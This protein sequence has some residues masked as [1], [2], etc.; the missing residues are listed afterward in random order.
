MSSDKIIDSDAIAESQSVS[1]GD[2][3]ARIRAE[4]THE[5]TWPPSLTTATMPLREL[6]AVMDFGRLADAAAMVNSGK[7]LGF[8]IIS[9]EYL[10]VGFNWINAIHRI[11]LTNFIMIA[12]DEVTA[13]ALD[14]RGIPN[15]LASIDESE[16]D[17]SYVSATGF[18]AKGLAVSAFKLPVAHF[19][20][21]LGYRAVLSDVDAIWLHDPMPYL[22][23]ADV[24]FQRIVYHPPAI[25]R[26]WGFAACGGYISFGNGRKT[27]AFL[28]RCVENHLSLYSDQVAINLTLLEQNPDWHCEVADW[29]VPAADLQCD[30]GGLEAAFE[31]Y[32]KWPIRG[33]LRQG[34]AQVLALPH[35]QF[36]R[37]GWVTSSSADMVICHPNSR[38]DGLEKMKLFDSMGLRFQPSVAD[39]R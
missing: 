23:S 12:G 34:G 28:E 16:F 11:G 29:T 33:E 25:A 15:V 20:V 26:L 10:E 6:S 3:T 32:S 1:G 37:H 38:K 7:E 13:K 18:S 17:A 5:Y 31:K 8:A 4:L 14:E 36:W 27:T 30:R 2:V 22:R 9:K 21:K 24:A 19:L 39:S 35:D